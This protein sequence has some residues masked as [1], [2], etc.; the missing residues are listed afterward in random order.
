MSF[1]LYTFHMPLFFF[2][3]GL[4]VPHSLRR[5]T[6]PFLSSK[7]W[8]LAYPY[9]L[10]SLIQGGVILLGLALRAYHPGRSD[11]RKTLAK[12]SDPGRRHFCNAPETPIRG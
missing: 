10:W 4:N 11:V 12:I 1:G 7:V 9:V 5:G 3:A 2:L 6:G 8:T